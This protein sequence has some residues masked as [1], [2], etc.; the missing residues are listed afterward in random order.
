MRAGLVTLDVLEDER[1]GDRA[2]YLGDRLRQQLTE[3]LSPY[4]MFKAAPGLG[5]LSGIEFR[6][7]QRL[8]LRLSFEAFRAIHPA[9]L[10]QVLVMRLFQREKILTQMCGNNFMVLKSAPPLIV[11]EE[12][13]AE[14]A[15]AAASV[16]ADVHESGTFWTDTLKLG[17]RT[18]RI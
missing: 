9:M 8:S 4:E 5:L 13:L 12:H 2:T 10:G 17:R 7:P 11:N 15:A 6:A 18:M 1:L 16:V 14:F 3:A